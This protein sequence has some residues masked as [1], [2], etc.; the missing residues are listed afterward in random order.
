MERLKRRQ[1]EVV[2]P[3]QVEKD[4]RLRPEVVKL[5]PQAPVVRIPTPAADKNW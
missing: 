3:L 5:P 2:N 4:K 1:P